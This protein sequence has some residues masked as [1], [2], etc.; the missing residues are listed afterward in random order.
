VADAASGAEDS[1]E[2]SEPGNRVLVL[3]A[4]FLLFALVATVAAV[5]SFWS[6]WVHPGKR[7]GG[8]AG[9]LRAIGQGWVVG[10]L[11]AVALTCLAAA[12]NEL[13]PRSARR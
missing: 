4:G 6:E 13:R 1:K 9:V 2:F 11:A 3:I 10:M 12:V 8:V 5:P 7:G